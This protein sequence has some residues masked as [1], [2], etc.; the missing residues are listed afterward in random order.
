MPVDGPQG[1]EPDAAPRRAAPRSGALRQ[2]SLREHNLAVTLRQVVDAEAPVS[3]A[4][5]AA[6]TGMARATVSNLVDWLV[7]AGMVTELEPRT[8]RG[9]G[10]P[11]VPLV[12]AGGTL[13]ALGMEVNVDYLGVRAVDLAGHV[14]AERT[15][16]DSFRGSDPGPVLVRLARLAERTLADLAADGVRVVGTAL[17]L[18][19]LVDRVDGP[20]RIA[21]NLGWRDVDVVAVLTGASHALAALP[22]RLANEANLAARAEA[23]VRRRATGS[24]P[25]FVYVS[26]EVGIGGAIVLDGRI[27]LGRHGWGG[28]IGHMVIDAPETGR[29]SLEEQ[30]GQDALMRAAGL[31]PSVQVSV[32]VEA[33]RSGDARAL[34]ALE[35]AGTALGM[36]LVNLVSAVDVSE[37]VLGGTFVPVYPWVYRAVTAELDRVIFADWA[38]VQVSVS[39]AGEYPAMT[40]AALAVLGA[41]VAAPTAFRATD[42]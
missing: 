12:P 6:A 10:R 4:E 1:G 35:H 3:R 23:Q 32:L 31:D 7:R 5:I 19:G 26:G 14:L 22:P 18:P 30:A 20:L 33:A 41:V 37:V 8:G 13:A 27:Y 40:G 11:A 16:R 15:Q 34:T 9:V 42:G 38:P 36:A 24:A 39:Q 28:E 2:E 29:R 25:S 17:A 21:P